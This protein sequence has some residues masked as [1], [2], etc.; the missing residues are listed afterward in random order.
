M[1]T[2]VAAEL[3]QP[4]AVAGRKGVLGRARN[5][6]VGLWGTVTGVAPHVLHH[7]GPLAGTALVAGAAGRLLFGTIGLVV[8]VPFLVRLHRRFRTWAAPAIAV[9]V[10]ALMFSL[11]TFVIGPLVTGE[12]GVDTPP[13]PDVTEPADHA[14]HNEH[15]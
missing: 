6:I 4:A 10:F 8:A 12:R 1:D 9:G 3:E 7:V 2:D 13:A 15:N 11:S 14:D 5:V